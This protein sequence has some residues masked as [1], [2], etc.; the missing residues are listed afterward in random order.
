MSTLESS[1]R[2]LSPSERP[3]RT[4]TPNQGKKLETSQLLQSSISS[5]SGGSD[6]RYRTLDM[7]SSQSPVLM[8]EKQRSTSVGSCD[9]PQVR[10]SIQSL[11][12]QFLQNAQS[13]R[14]S[15]IK[16][17][18]ETVVLP[19]NKGAVKDIIARIQSPPRENSPGVPSDTEVKETQIKQ[20]QASRGSVK[21]KI[22]QYKQ[23]TG[24]REASERKDFQRVSTKKISELTK[25]FEKE[26]D[27]KP[28]NESFKRKRRSS[29]GRPI[30]LSPPKSS[31]SR[32]K[33]SRGDSQTSLKSSSDAAQPQS[34]AP[35]KESLE[36]SGD[37]VVSNLPGHPAGARITEQFVRS[38]SRED[39]IIEISTYPNLPSSPHDRSKPKR[40]ETPESPSSAER[41][42]TSPSPEPERSTPSHKSLASHRQRSQSDISHQARMHVTYRKVEPTLANTEHKDELVFIM[43]IIILKNFS[44]VMCLCVD[45]HTFI[46]FL[47]FFISISFFMISCL[48]C[49]IYV[50]ICDIYTLY[51]IKKHYNYK[52]IIRT[53][54]YICIICTLYIHGSLYKCIFQQYTS[55]M[56]V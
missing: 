9:S 25:G 14:N 53:Y 19:Q 6:S 24:E 29:D 36:Y 8:R 15:S 23:V 17:S 46:F 16:S 43:Y 22:S 13:S 12:Q 3:S 32:G 5:S 10:A 30:V 33:Y 1:P 56:Y 45:V 31:Q 49:S 40:N 42:S 51:I 11:Q 4:P 47:F 54:I 52:H 34:P 37:F 18:H 7:H 44:V 41:L 2:S 20:F 21:E 26:R 39:E 38:S 35:R 48:W 28:Q 27:K 50:C 55:Y